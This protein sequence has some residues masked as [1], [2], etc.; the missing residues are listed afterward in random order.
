MPLHL[1]ILFF[2]F[3]AGI[4]EDLEKE[5][6]V[7]GEISNKSPKSATCQHCPFLPSCA[8]MRSL[9]KIHIFCKLFY[10]LSHWYLNIFIAYLLFSLL[11]PCPRQQK[12]Y[13]A[14]TKASLLLD[15]ESKT[16]DKIPLVLFSKANLMT[17]F[18]VGLQKSIPAY[19]HNRNTF[20]RSHLFQSDNF[21]CVYSSAIFF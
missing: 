3:W 4:R 15:I 7:R 19:P 14:C 12:L 13:S 9:Q 1:F 2:F 16:D 11:P 20:F 8:E 21:E 18:T 6:G 10:S 17:C 5:A